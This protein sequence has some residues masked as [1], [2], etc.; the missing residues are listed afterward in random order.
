MLFADLALLTIS[1]IFSWVLK[2]F[3]FGGSTYFSKFL[4]FSFIIWI[5]IFFLSKDYKIGRNNNYSRTLKKSFSSTFIFVAVFLFLT[6]FSEEGQVSRVFLATFFL[7]VISTFSVYRVLLHMLLVKYRVLGGNY[8]TAVILGYDDLGFSLFNTLRSQDALGIRCDGIYGSEKTSDSEVPRLGT[9]Q[10]FIDSDRSLIDFIYVS[11][12]LEKGL[13]NQVIEIGDREFKKVKL[14]PNFKTDFLKTY[15]L[16]LVDQISVIDVNSLP[17]D[18]LSNRFVKR[19]FDIVFSLSVVVLILS[20]LYPLVSLLIK[21]E[22]NGPVIFRQLR[23]GKS[24]REF[25]CLKFR[26]M[27]LNDAADSKWATKNDPRV[28]KIGAFLRRTSLDELPQFINVLRGEMAIVGPRPLPVKMNKHFESRVDKFFQRHTYKPGIT[29]LAQSMGYRGEI[30]EL[31]DIRKRV[32]LDRFY[33][34]NWTFFFDLKII[35]RTVKALV[36]GQE[37]AY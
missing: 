8:R 22:S 27:V 21:L 15:S 2:E 6:F 24:N 36:L 7:T 14:L 5:A 19:S 28:T 26:T 11:D 35:V 23:N 3:A 10:E 32:K 30:Q 13:L 9:I 1:L 29:G 17:L 20:W 34:Q 16:R 18:S 33:F 31:F 12:N 37:S 25:N 4:V